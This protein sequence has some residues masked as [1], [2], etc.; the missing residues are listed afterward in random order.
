MHFLLQRAD[1][2]LPG[3]LKFICDSFVLSI[4][5]FRNRWVK[6]IVVRG[7]ALWPGL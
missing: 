4:G 5:Q 7:Y 3:N 2:F 1:P 6:M